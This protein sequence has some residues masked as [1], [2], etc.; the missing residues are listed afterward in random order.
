[1]GCCGPPALSQ[2]VGCRLPEFPDLIPGYRVSSHLQVFG[3]TSR[4]RVVNGVGT[5]RRREEH[6]MEPGDGGAGHYN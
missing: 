2:G 6:G 4:S 5:L 3:H 1:M